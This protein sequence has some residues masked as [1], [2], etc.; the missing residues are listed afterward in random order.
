VPRAGTWVINCVDGAKTVSE[1]VIVTADGEIFNVKVNYPVIAYSTKEDLLSDSP[2]ES[3]I[4]IIND[5]AV[6]SWDYTVSGPDSPIPGM[7]WI[8]IGDDGIASRVRQYISDIW[9]DVPAYGYL[10]GEWKKIPVWLFDNGDE[11]EYTTG[12]WGGTGLT[13]SANKLIIGAVSNY[14]GV[15]WTTNFVDLS[16]FKT[17]KA[18]VNTTIGDDGAFALLISTDQT[19]VNSEVGVIAKTA[20]HAKGVYAD[21]VVSLDIP[22]D[23]PSEKYYIKLFQY[24]GTKTNTLDAS[25][26]WLE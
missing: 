6:T 21:H 24:D 19:A 10:G 26:V 15:A 20:V 7:V 3:T 13:K 18:K 5:T 16:G 14:R 17:V 4:G 11:I 2:M 8:I 1:D 22:T 9:I 12:G 25:E 23:L